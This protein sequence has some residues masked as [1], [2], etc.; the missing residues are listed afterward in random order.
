M[1]QTPPRPGDRARRVVKRQTER[2]AE[3]PFNRRIGEQK[4]ELTD[5]DGVGDK[6]AQQMRGEGFRDPSD[7]YREPVDNLT[8]LD[9]VGRARAED[10]Q[11]A[12]ATAT[13][14][15]FEELEDINGV[16]DTTA[17]KLKDA[18]IRDSHELRGKRQ[19]TL[20]AIDGIGP[21]RAARIRADVEYEA[22]AG[23]TDTG[24]NVQT[25]SGADVFRETRETSL[26]PFNDS[27]K[28]AEDDD[29]VKPIAGNVGVRG[30]DRREA[31][32]RHAERTEEARQADESFN[33]PIMLDVDTWAQNPGKYDYPG[34]DT[35]PRSRKLERARDLAARAKE[36]GFLGDIQADTEA[37]NDWRARGSFSYG[38]VEVDT[39]FR[40]AE[41]T[42]T[43]ELGHAVDSGTGRPSGV[44]ARGN[45][46][47]ESIF[48]DDAVLEQASELSAQR[49]GRELDTEYLES[50]N[51]IFADLV[52]EATTNPRRAKKEAPDA[53]RAL[54]DAVGMEVGFFK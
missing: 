42:L 28:T 54:N 34:V 17:R 43:H 4:Y 44:D 6:L 20:A 25:E 41:D 11:D 7:V 38:K 12:A 51:E 36:A 31:I 35:I 53:V 46:A 18:G 21:K 9:G 19:S 45:D 30:P 52:A 5:I 2:I 14:S 16:G 24:Y 10:I 47:G 3:D 50:Q 29:G 37:T 27:I 26:A 49:R 39:S 22:P 40:Q 33:A 48:D 23:A 32:A 1:V 13:R 8:Q 15:D